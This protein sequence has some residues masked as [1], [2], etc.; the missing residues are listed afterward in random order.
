MRKVLLGAFIALVLLYGGCLALLA[1]E[2]EGAGEVT[3]ADGSCLEPGRNTV[4]SP[5]TGTGDRV[6]W[7]S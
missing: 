1:G 7:T 4:T 5:A 6:P 2:A 3:T